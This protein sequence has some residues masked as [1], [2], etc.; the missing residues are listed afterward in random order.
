MHPSDDQTDNQAADE[1]REPLIPQ[2]LSVD[3]LR[4]RWST[5]RQRLG[6]LL[7]NH[8]TVIR[9]HRSL[10]WL[11]HARNQ[12]QKQDHDTALLSLWI[13]LNALYGQ[14]NTV[15]R[16]PFP[17]R[18][19]WIRFFDKIRTLDRTHHISR[20]LKDQR[21]IVMRLLDDPYLSRFFWQDPSEVQ[22]NKSRKTMFNARTWY[23][24]D[25]FSLILESVLERIYLLRCQLV[26]GAATFASRLNRSALSDCIILLEHILSVSLLVIID[27]GA[28]ANWGEMCYPPYDPQYD[29]QTL[30]E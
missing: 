19:S 20:M 15:A 2:N 24:Q 17:D 18:E 1:A 13:S 12:S 6:T 7:R 23:V 27:H 26:H 25:K 11:E 30:D 28:D 16:E 22:A 4:Q 29:P 5:H 9:I 21:E 3:E 8:P 14:W 10:S